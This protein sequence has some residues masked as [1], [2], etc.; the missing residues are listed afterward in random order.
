MGK[1]KVLEVFCLQ[2]LLW[3][4]EHSTSPS[5]NKKNPFQCKSF[6]NQ[7]L[8]WGSVE[9]MFF[10]FL[11]TIWTIFEVKFREKLLNLMKKFSY[12]FFKFFE[13]FNIKFGPDSTTIFYLMIE[14][15]ITTQN[16]CLR[17]V[18]TSSYLVS[19]IWCSLISLTTKKRFQLL[20]LISFLH[21]ILF[22]AC[23]ISASQEFYSSLYNIVIVV[24]AANDAHL[25]GG[26]ITS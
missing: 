24:F 26:C 3:Q 1:K 21:Q 9:N 25:F 11:M 10:S 17:D 18:C 14:N 19:V 13:T 20:I 23:I 16:C 2:I 6:C 5:Y 4:R 8:S 12:N 7:G 22:C 15:S